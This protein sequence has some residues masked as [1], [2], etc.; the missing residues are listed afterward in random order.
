MKIPIKYRS[1]ILATLKKMKGFRKIKTL[2]EEVFKY[3]HPF[4]DT[5]PFIESSSSPLVCGWTKWLLRMR[6]K[7]Q[8]LTSELGYK[9][10]LQHPPYYLASLF[11]GE[12]KAMFWRSQGGP[13]QRFTGWGINANNSQHKPASCVSEHLGMEPSLPC[14]T[15]KCYRHSQ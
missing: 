1:A 10:T 13:M 8:C 5:P 12:P 6:Y 2:S 7:L 11:L 9:K 3:T 15:L 4:F 14:W